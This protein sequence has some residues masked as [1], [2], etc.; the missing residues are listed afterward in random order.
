MV[1]ERGNTIEGGLS[2]SGNN[3]IINPAGPGLS[4][5]ANMVQ[6]VTIVATQ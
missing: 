4:V 5:D 2:I 6:N 3:L 1:S